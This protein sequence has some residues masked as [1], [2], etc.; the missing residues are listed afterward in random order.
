MT[1]SEGTI[2]VD[3]VEV[4]VGTPGRLLDLVNRKSLNLSQ[5]AI[6]VLDEADEMLDLGFLA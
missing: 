1:S 4:V 6:L 3:G 5:V 2:I